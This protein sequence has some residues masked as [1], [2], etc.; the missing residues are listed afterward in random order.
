VSGLQRFAGDAIHVVIP[1]AHLDTNP[2]DGV[3]VHRTSV[4][5][6]ADIDARA[7][8]PCTRPPRSVVDAARWARTDREARTIIAVCFQQRLVS[9]DE[10]RAVLD[11]LTRVK[12][13]ALIRSTVADAADGSETITELDLVRVC[14]DGGLPVP[15]RQVIRT[16]S[17]GR[18]RYLDAYFDEWG[19]QVEVDGM[20]HIEADQWWN[21]MRR[22]NA[23]SV[24]GEV[25]L[26]FPAFLLRDAPAEVLTELRTALLAAGWLPP[27]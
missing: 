18:K 26:R 12:R 22:H 25:L 3:R 21:D 6:A 11:R 16:D 15:S 8:P 4:L 13:R 1:A 20:H 5:P 7:D 14:R 10:I 17:S 23:L 19:I 2:P 27:R 9:G 24:R